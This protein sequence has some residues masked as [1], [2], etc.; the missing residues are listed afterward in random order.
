[1]YGIVSKH[2]EVLGTSTIYKRL[3]STNVFIVYKPYSP[4]AV[5]KHSLSFIL[6]HLQGRVVAAAVAVEEVR[7]PVILMWR[8]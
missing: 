4:H 3:Q 5:S 1:M 6:I 2:E 8:Q 7:D